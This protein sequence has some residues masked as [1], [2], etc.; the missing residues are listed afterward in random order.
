FQVND[1]SEV[2]EAQANAASNQLISSVSYTLPTNVDVMTLT[3]TAGLSATGNDDAG[4]IIT[5]NSGNDTLAAGSGSDTLVSGTGASTLV[6]GIGPDTFVVNNSA[7]VVEPQAYNGWQDTIESSVSYTLTAAVSTLQLTGAAD[8][9]AV[10][11]YGDASITGNAGND[12]LTAGSGND[13]LVAGTGVDTLVAGA[14]S[15]VFVIDNAADVIQGPGATGSDTVQSSVSFSLVQGV[16]TLELTGSGNVEG[17]G[18][19]DASNQITAN[20]GNDTLIAGTGKDTLVAG[21]GN[22]SLVAGS[23]TDVLEGGAD[24]VCLQR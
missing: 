18:N 4:N 10:D 13:T 2:V 21:A 17:D 5:G 12:T 6:G 9:S 20:S 8:L 11:D 23:G 22:D 1:A 3:G 16:D 14:G 19:S 24:H 15:T 7:D